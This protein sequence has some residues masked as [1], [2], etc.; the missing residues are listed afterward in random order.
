MDTLQI[1]LGLVAGT[2]LPLLAA[3]FIPNSTFKTWGINIGKKLSEQGTKYVGKETWQKLENT[4][5]GSFVAF[6]DGLKEGAE[7]DN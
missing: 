6:S 2:A 7:S 4:I 3:K 5:V 1:I